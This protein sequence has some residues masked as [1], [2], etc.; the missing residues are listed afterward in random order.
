[1]KIKAA[2]WFAPVTLFLAA[3]L[4]GVCFAQA[5]LAEPPEG[6][7][8][9]VAPA[10]QQDLIVAS[11]LPGSTV[12]ADVQPND[13]NVLNEENTVSEASGPRESGRSAF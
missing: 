12:Q 6:R 2:L 1:M 9:A 3:V 8:A 4:T 11:I 5:G 7:S 13:S 10:P